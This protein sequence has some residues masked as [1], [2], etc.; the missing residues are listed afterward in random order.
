MTWSNEIA[1][2]AMDHANDIG[3]KGQTSHD[4]SDGNSLSD[5]LKRYGAPV[6]SYGEN[7]SFGQDK[8]LDVVVQLLVDDGVPG[9]GHRTNIFNPA[10]KVLG[11]ATGQHKAYTYMTCID[12]AG[13]YTLPG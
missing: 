6:S 9:R 12:Y 4:G 7:L 2:A 8:A 13:G 5:R 3:P 1:K 11:S 10:F